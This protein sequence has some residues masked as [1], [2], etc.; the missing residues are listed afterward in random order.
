MDKID[1]WVNFCFS[2]FF[3]SCGISMTSLF[4]AMIGVIARGF[5]PR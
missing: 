4:G 5:V 1:A 3:L 2:V